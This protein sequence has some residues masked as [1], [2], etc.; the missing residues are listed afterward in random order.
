MSSRYYLRNK[1]NP[2]KDDLG[3]SRHQTGNISGKM[4]NR[5]NDST[6]DSDSD[7]SPERRSASPEFRMECSVSDHDS[8]DS[9][10]TDTIHSSPSSTTGSPSAL[11]P[12]PRLARRVQHERL[13]S[14]ESGHG[15]SFQSSPKMRRT[16]AEVSSFESS[17]K[18]RVPAAGK[19]SKHVTD[20][21][22]FLQTPI[23]IRIFCILVVVAVALALALKL[24]SIYA[25]YSDDD[26]AMHATKPTEF[27]EFI[28]R[29][30]ELRDVFPSQDER[31]W[32]T[33][34]SS[35]KHVLDGKDPHYPAVI[36]FAVPKSAS[37]LGTCFAQQVAQKFKNSTRLNK[38]IDCRHSS[39]LDP[40]DAKLDLDEKIHAHFQTGKAV[41]IDHLEMLSPKSV[42][43]L[44]GTC[45]NDNAPFKDVLISLVFHLDIP[46]DID[47]KRVEDKVEEYLM[48]GLDVDKVGAM[49]SRIANNIVVI[50][51][52]QSG[53]MGKVCPQL[54]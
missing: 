20:W 38:Y 23:V 25:G 35:V 26:K 29:V 46:R 16:Q 36:L 19:G 6:T 49:L 43:L 52:E 41:V 15:Q 34:K 5:R 28:K 27:Q 13:S 37:K 12:S 22:K 31:T 54:K 24:V 14:P 42:L 11:T 4:P 51:H 10:P 1:P 8:L 2:K 3:D 44:H 30:N 48:S 40:A 39:H 17:H 33:L 32:K 18:R 47:H 53:L 50:R 9:V 7:Y 21:Y 45:D